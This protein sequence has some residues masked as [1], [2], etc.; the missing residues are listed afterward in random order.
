MPFPNPRAI[1]LMV[2]GPA[3][4]Q[5]VIIAAVDDDL[6]ERRCPQE[7]SRIIPTRSWRLLRAGPALTVAN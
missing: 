5:C 6:S 1:D 3:R 2:D 7:S 4:H